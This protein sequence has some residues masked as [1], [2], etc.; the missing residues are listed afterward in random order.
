[1]HLVV[2][3]EPKDYSDHIKTVLDLLIHLGITPKNKIVELN[4]DVYNED[5]FSL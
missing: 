1:M 2:N 3:G 5:S 4:G